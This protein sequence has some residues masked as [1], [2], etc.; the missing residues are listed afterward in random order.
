V[1]NYLKK[2]KQMSVM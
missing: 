1:H 2:N